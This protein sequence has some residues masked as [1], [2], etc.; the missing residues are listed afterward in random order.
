MNEHVSLLGI[1]ESTAIKGL[2]IVLIVLGH[3]SFFTTM[4][5][6]VQMMGYLYCFHIQCFFIIP[7]L[8]GAKPF[9]IKRCSNYF[10]RLYW[11]YII[12]TTLLYIGYYVIYENN[13]FDVSILLNILLWGQ[14]SKLS[15]YCGVQIL[16]F[17]PAMF[18]LMVIKDIYYSSNQFIKVVLLLISAV[19]L[20]ISLLSEDW[21]YYHHLFAS[22]LPNGLPMALNAA[23]PFLIWGVISRKVIE[24]LSS[25]H[26]NMLYILSM[27]FVLTIL[28]FANILLWQRNIVVLSSLMGLFPILFIIIL[29]KAKYALSNV[30]FLKACGTGSFQIYIMHPFIGYL[31]LFIMADF[32]QYTLSYKIGIILFSTCMMLMGGYIFAMIVE[33]SPL[34]K[35][36]FFPRSF[37]DFIGREK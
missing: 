4:T 25:N 16:W 34:I 36:Y 3:N 31:L 22:L 8:Y 2:L 14:S 35:R 37:M 7:F 18:S 30:K 10:M 6:P 24:Y 33:R 19:F 26:V 12:I 5:E 29:Y 9:S 15:T 21:G 28:Y 11:P 27:W 20:V 32:V 23:M 1:N 17:M 13:T